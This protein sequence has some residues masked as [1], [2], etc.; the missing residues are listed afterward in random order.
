MRKPRGT[1]GP[2][3]ASLRSLLLYCPPTLANMTR[4][5]VVS[6][7]SRIRAPLGPMSIPTA[8]TGTF[9]TTASGLKPWPRR[10][11]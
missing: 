9:T 6:R 4:A 1:R 5:P 8:R 11:K 3:R 7:S 10:P 2:A